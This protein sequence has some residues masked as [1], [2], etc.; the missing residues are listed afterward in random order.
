MIAVSVCP[1]GY[2]PLDR[3]E[4]ARASRD[5]EPIISTTFYGYY[6]GITNN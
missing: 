4:L 3:Q 6:Y 1:D 2:Y 5:D